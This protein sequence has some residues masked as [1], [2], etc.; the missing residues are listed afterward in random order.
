MIVPTRVHFPRAAS[1]LTVLSAALL[2]ACTTVPTESAVQALARASWAMESTSI[3]NITFSGSGTGATFGQAFVP[4][5]AWPRINYSSMV[6]MADYENGAFREDAARSRAEP[7][8]GGAVPLLG[9][10][11]Q[12]TTGLARGD[13]AWNLVGPAPIP[14]PVALTGRIHDLWTT[15]HGVIKAAMANNPTIRMHQLDGRT[16][17]AIDFQV[18]GRFSATAYIGADGMIEGVD[19]VQP[20]PVMGDTASQIR[21]TGYKIWGT[22]KFPSRIQQSMGGHPILDLQ[23][24][25]V[26]ANAN[27][28]IEVPALVP[29]FAERV[30]AEPAAEGV[31][32]LAGGS[33]NSVAIEMRDHM[34]V[35]EAPLYDGRSTAVL[36]EASRLGKGKPVRFV[37][38][39]HHHFDHAGGLRSAVAAGATLV[40]SAAAKP[41]FDGVLANPNRIR[42]DALQT[43]GRRAEVLGLTG[44]QH[45]FDDGSRRVEV[46]SI[47]GSVHAQ[48]F[49]M[50]WLPK[51]RILIQADA[52]TPAAPNTPA[53]ARANDLHVNLVQNLER[54]G[55]QPERLLPL[56]GRMVAMRDLLAMIG[57]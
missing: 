18:P 37:I 57:R 21:F 56:H 50:V 48:G 1:W 53:P 14:S 15:P 26:K 42:P 49:Q 41:W 39:S 54:Q 36:Q 9:Q 16:V 3:R 12:R 7:N 13:W 29:A 25:E 32:F 35:V 6:R 45:V 38:N 52:Y 40:T 34:I 2:S 4:G 28:A 20:N 44:G 55:I 31:W 33:H 46:R 8:G 24:S 43:S 19:S 30:V 22:V 5:Q 17:T 47:D 27:A 23:V 10:G 11:E 51:E